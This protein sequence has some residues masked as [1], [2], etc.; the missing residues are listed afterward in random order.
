MCVCA[1]IVLIGEIG[2]QAEETAAEYLKEYNTVRFKCF[3]RK[4]LVIVRKESSV[5]NTPI[6]LCAG[7]QEEAGG[8]IHRWGNGATW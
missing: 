1:G 6:L 8:S 5:H 4:S 7:P 3:C 2:G